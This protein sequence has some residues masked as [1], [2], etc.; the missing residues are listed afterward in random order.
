MRVKQ[1]YEVEL[2]RSPQLFVDTVCVADMKS[3]DETSKYLNLHSR[4]QL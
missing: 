3:S 1:T 2:H 4:Y